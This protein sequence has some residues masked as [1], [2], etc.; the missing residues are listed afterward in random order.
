MKRQ[1]IGHFTGRGFYLREVRHAI[2]TFLPHRGLALRSSDQ[3]VRW[4]DR[5]LVVMALLMA[6]QGSAVLQDAFE[7]CWEAV[8]GMYPTRR[9]VGHTY[10]GFS[11]A[12]VKH[13]AR[14]LAV[15]RPALRQAVVAVAGPCWQVAGWT[16]MSVDGSRFESPRTRANEA[17]FGCA[18][19]KK[20]GPQQSLTTVLHLGTGL[21]WD[22]RRGG[23]KEAERTHLREMLAGLP[24]A[25]LLVADAGFT[26]YELLRELR[27]RGHSFVLRV[28][29]NVRLLKKLGY[30]VRE[31]EDLVYLWPEAQRR[32]HPPLLLRLVVVRDGRRAMYLL[33]D[34]LEE[35]KLSDGQVVALYRR[36]WGIE[37]FYR[38]LKR[39]LEKY[40]VRSAAPAQAAV[41]LE[42][43]VA[44]MWLLGLMTVQRLRRRQLKP[45]DLS[46]AQAL[47]VL[48]RVLAG[49][50]PRR[51]A[52]KLAALATAVKDL[53][54]RRGSKSTRLWP[55]KKT[56][57]PPGA[58]KIRTA[59]PKERQKIQE[60]LCKKP[61]A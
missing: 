41:E 48:R 61:A 24:A 4:T 55:R 60:F 27:A 40:K 39:T 34:V 3:R 54:R 37:V 20:T 36:R 38:S 21:L 28:G 35:A 8:V 50:G 47:R 32:S 25:S 10:E 30:A 13:S 19:R 42:W 12:L 51:G 33:T 14:L 2:S 43:A 29:C 58:P 53:Y 56:E 31:Q 7:A 45:T 16:A 44:G 17:A 57:R 52:R 18:G 26:G 23:G 11:K 1:R 49:R 22:W 5:L 6:W 9:R 46:V 59:T 15:V